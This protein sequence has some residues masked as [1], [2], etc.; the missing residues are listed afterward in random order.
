MPTLE[1]LHSIGIG[2]P[3]GTIAWNAKK[4][5]G[6][7]DTDPA[8]I[9]PKTGEKQHGGRRDLL[10]YKGYVTIPGKAAQMAARH[11]RNDKRARPV[12]VDTVG[13]QG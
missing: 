3:R 1:V 11:S 8:F 2:P 6:P 7:R 12:E 10:Y 4:H 5:R 9:C 13:I